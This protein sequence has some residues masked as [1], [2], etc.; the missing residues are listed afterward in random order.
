MRGAFRLSC[1]IDEAALTPRPLPLDGSALTEL[2]TKLSF[3]QRRAPQ[4]VP[5]LLSTECD[6][7]LT[8]RFVR[9]T[10]RIFKILRLNIHKLLH[11]FQ[12]Q[13]ITYQSGY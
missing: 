10:V 3:L 9:P 2:L 4:V 5:Y 1:F 13:P 8:F 7:P 6:T 11:K 12:I